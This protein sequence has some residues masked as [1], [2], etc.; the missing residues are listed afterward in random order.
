MTARRRALGGIVPVSGA[1]SGLER[2]PTLRAPQSK[3]SLRLS[4]GGAGG[5]RERSIPVSAAYPPLPQVTGA[6][7]SDAPAAASPV[8]RGPSPRGLLL[9]TAA[10]SGLAWGSGCSGARK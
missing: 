7:S 5:E 4:A 8:P 1:E 2:G 3:R 6:K 10:G 9:Q